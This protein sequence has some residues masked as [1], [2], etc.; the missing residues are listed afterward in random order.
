MHAD[1]AAI[2]ADFLVQRIRPDDRI[3]PCQ[4]PA[5]EVLHLLVQ[6]FCHLA[7]LASGEI[8]NSQTMGQLLHLPGGHTL[9]ERLLND[10]NQRRLAALTLC[11]K[12]RDVSTAAQLWHHEVHRSHTGIQSPGAVTAA[13]IVTGRIVCVLFRAND[14]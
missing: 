10:L 14:A 3:V 2:Y 8:F 12:K 7:D 11:D 4:G 1:D 13:I 9:Y 6:A 5:A